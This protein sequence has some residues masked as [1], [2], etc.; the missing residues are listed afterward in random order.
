MPTVN[1]V[2]R[3]RVYCTLQN[4][5]AINVLHWRV[6]GIGG[7]GLSDQDMADKLSADLAPFYKALISSGATY[8]GLSLQRISPGP[9]PIEVH[10]INAQG[11]GTGDLTRM[12]KQVCG[13][14]NRKTTFAGRSEIA[15]TYVPFPGEDDNGDA[16]AAPTA[17]YMTRLGALAGHLIGT[18]V[19]GTGGDTVSIIPVIWHRTTS[20]STVIVTA[21]A[22]QRW[23]TQRRRGDFGRPNNPPF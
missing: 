18:I 14:F 2:Y 11:I 23:A 15:R 8:W 5:T 21:Q 7:A 4:Q 12:P 17:G 6:S 3:A 9:I 20:S 13:Y 19:L 16:T 1:D 10:T 22:K